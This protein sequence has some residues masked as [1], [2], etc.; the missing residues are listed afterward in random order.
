MLD[1]CEVR[2]LHVSI[3]ENCIGH[4]SFRQVGTAQGGS[5]PARYT[6][7]CTGE[8][9]IREESSVEFRVQEDGMRETG[10]G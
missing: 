10:L 7:V 6:Q 9:A 8:V 1:V 5:F 4:V 2:A 3:L